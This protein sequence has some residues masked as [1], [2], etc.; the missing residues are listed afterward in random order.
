MEFIWVYDTT[1]IDPNIGINYVMENEFDLDDM[2]DEMIY[3]AEENLK[4]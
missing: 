1:F 4:N 3:Q 2:I